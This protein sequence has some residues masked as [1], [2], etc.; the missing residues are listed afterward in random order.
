MLAAA[1]VIHG[2]SARIYSARYQA[3]SSVILSTSRR[4]SLYSRHDSLSHDS[5][6]SWLDCILFYYMVYV[7]KLLECFIFSDKNNNL[8]KRTTSLERTNGSSPCC[9][10]FGGSTVC[11]YRHLS[12]SLSLSRHVMSSVIAYYKWFHLWI[13]EIRVNDDLE[14]ELWASVVSVAGASC[15]ARCATY[16]C[17]YVVLCPCT[18]CVCTRALMNGWSRDP[19]LVSWRS[20]HRDHSSDHAVT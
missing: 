7:S 3:L 11:H 16:V 9:P 20:S 5:T 4:P 15:E 17:M 14:R 13:G 1:P 8:R 12:L 10:L 19:G 2:D 6:D 18:L